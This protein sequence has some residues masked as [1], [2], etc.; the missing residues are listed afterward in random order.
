MDI[1]QKSRPAEFIGLVAALTAMVAMTIDTMLPAIGVMARELGAAHE[2]DRQLIILVFFAGLALGTLIFGPISDSTGRKPAIYAGLGFYLVGCLMCYFATSFPILIAGRFVQ[3]FGA[4]APRVVSMAMVRDGARGADMARIMSYVM[5]V[6]MLVPI[7]APSIGQLV[8]N[9]GDWRVIFL[10]FMAMATLAGLWLAVRQEETLAPENRHRFEAAALWESAVAVVKHPV[11]FGY[12]IAVGFVFAAFNVYLATCQQVFAE[13]YHQGSYFA[14]WFGGFAVGLAIAM[15]VNGR[16]V[17]RL[18]M[19]P[20]S[21]YA[22]WAFIANWG[23][24]LVASLLTDG[25]PPLPLVAALN[26]ISFFASG[27]IF[28]NYNAMAMEP[29]GRIAGM[30]AAVSGS[31]S[32][33]MAIILGGSAAR[34]YDGTMTPVALAFVAFGGLAWAASEWAERNRPAAG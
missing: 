21:K 6:F 5:S 1:M 28:G 22:L 29:M 9:F 7:I 33:V 10:G 14:L 2:N 23:V 24:M 31:L 16:T 13:Q 32:S 4:A 25:Q 30:A 12:T 27:M 18:G 19:R 8:L 15:I 11:A 34:Q 3:G 20:L 17:K 26:F